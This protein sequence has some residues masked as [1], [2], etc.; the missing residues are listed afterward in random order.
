MINNESH[1]NE[2]SLKSIFRS[3]IRPIILTMIAQITGF[4]FLFFLEVFLDIEFSTQLSSVVN[5]V[6]VGLVAFLVF[7]RR[8][9]IPFGRIGGRDFLRKVGFY[10]PESA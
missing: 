1:S 3:R 7:P 6:L 4:T 9:G 5:L 8:L 10:L 2:K